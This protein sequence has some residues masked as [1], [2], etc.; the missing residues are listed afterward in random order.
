MNEQSL[1]PLLIIRGLKTME[2][3]PKVRDY[4][5]K[6]RLLL[7]LK[8]YRICRRKVPEVLTTDII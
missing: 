8:S 6:Q 5:I 1:I 4:G 2:I 3:Y 7:G